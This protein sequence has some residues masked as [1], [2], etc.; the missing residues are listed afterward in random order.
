M[1]AFEQEK[2]DLGAKASNLGDKAKELADDVGSKAKEA[3]TTLTQ[4]VGDAASFVGKKA[5]EAASSIGSGMKSLGGGI[6][7]HTPDKGTVGAATGAVA[8]TLETSGHYLQE[9]RLRGVGED[10]TNLIRRNPIPSVLIGVGLGFLVAR[11]TIRS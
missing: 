10:L 5:E 7:A 4:K 11:A 1:A 2:K 6:R 3:A 9:H 8:D